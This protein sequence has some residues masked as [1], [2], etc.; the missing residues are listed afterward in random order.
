MERDFLED[1]GLNRNITIKW[2]FK[3]CYGVGMDRIDLA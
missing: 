2:N 3:K 1:L